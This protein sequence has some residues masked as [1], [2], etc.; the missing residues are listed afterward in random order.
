[1][2]EKFAHV[3]IGS[4]MALL[5][6]GIILGTAATI[7]DDSSPLKTTKGSTTIHIPTH[8]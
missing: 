5:F 2:E 3:Y 1:M 7:F 6:F 4:I 8:E